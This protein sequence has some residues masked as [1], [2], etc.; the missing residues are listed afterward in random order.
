MDVYQNENEIIVQSA[1]AGAKGEDIDIAIAKDAVTIKGFRARMEKNDL[2]D[3]LH[4]EMHWGEFS[5]SVILPADIN[6]DQARASIKNGL[7]TIRLPKLIR[8]T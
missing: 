7:L 6:V 5:R 1:V 3:Y 4:Q 8:G 2:H